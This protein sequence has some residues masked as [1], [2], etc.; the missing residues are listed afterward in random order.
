MEDPKGGSG[1]LIFGNPGASPVDGA[2]AL[3][4]TALGELSEILEG[5]EDAG[6]CGKASAF[7]MES[8]SKRSDYELQAPVLR[9]VAQAIATELAGKLAA[10]NEAVNKGDEKGYLK[11]HAKP[12]TAVALMQDRDESWRF[13]V[14]VNGSNELRA[15]KEQYLNAI[16]AQIAGL[17][18]DVV[19][20][21]DALRS[22]LTFEAGRMKQQLQEVKSGRRYEN[23]HTREERRD[24]HGVAKP[25]LKA[26]T[27]WSWHAEQ[28]LLR[29]VKSVY[30]RA[31]RDSIVALGISHAEGPCG[32]H[33]QATPGGKASNLDHCDE[34]LSR[35][36]LRARYM[37]NQDHSVAAFWYSARKPK[38]SIADLNQHSEQALRNLDRK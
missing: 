25:P 17:P 28:K 26:K 19:I 9:Y 32:E 16:P 20:D 35:K 13:I 29:Y 14:A 37:D 21:D 1:R 4:D 7:E 31:Q 2:E 3:E 36:Y 6:N 15:L 38:C 27:V 5:V 18:V 8:E 23:E 24:A 34:Y 12:V 33:T 10:H 30:G 22:R 11:T